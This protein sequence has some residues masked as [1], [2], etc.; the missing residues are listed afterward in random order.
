MKTIIINIAVGLVIIALT[1][2]L[3]NQCSRKKD[4]QKELVTATIEKQQ[5]VNDY[6]TLIKAK[7]RID[8]LYKDGKTITIRKTDFKTITDTF[9]IENGKVYGLFKDSII[10]KDLSLRAEIVASD[11]KSVEYTYNVREKIITK[12]NIVYNVDTVVSMIR[13]R[14]LYGLADVGIHTYS[15]GLQYQGRKRLGVTARYNWY[16]SDRFVTVG[17]VYRIF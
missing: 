9:L 15:A 13:P 12:E 1:L 14:S 5:A 17:V 11:L 10:N 4:A 2:L 6:M 8:T 16:Q 3:V 7:Q